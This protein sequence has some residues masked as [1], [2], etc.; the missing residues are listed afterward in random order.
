MLPIIYNYKKGYIERIYIE[1]KKQWQTENGPYRIYHPDKKYTKI[2]EQ[3]S[4]L[5][6]CTRFDSY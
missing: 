1:K 4:L 2:T 5:P 3:E 6:F